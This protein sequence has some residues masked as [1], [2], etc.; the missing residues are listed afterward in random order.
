[1]TYRFIVKKL[2]FIGLII[3]G[4]NTAACKGGA[5]CG[6]SVDPLSDADSD[7]L[8][9]S[10]DNCPLS[11]NPAQFDGDED[12]VGNICD[13]DDA[14]DTVG[15]TTAV[16]DSA[17]LQLGLDAEG[18]VFPEDAGDMKIYDLD[19]PDCEYYIISCDNQWLGWADNDDSLAD[20]F[21]EVSTYARSFAACSALN[22][23]AKYP[24]A[25]FCDKGDEVYFSGYL[26][27]N[28]DIHYGMDS[29]EALAPHLDEGEYCL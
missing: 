23:E 21:N 18:Y 6:P 15:T 9:D 19:D 12:G 25:V 2:F 4:L 7:C 5:K 27:T 13:S 22:D 26:T 14:D 20:S 17:F 28:P 1:M 8:I 3:I 16:S 29:C 24:P 10:S 11:Y